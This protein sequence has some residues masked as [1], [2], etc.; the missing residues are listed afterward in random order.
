MPVTPNQWQRRPG[1]GEVPHVLCF[2]ARRPAEFCGCA[3]LISCTVSMRGP[4]ARRTLVERFD[5][6]LPESKTTAPPSSSEAP[7]ARWQS[8]P[9]PAPASAASAQEKAGRNVHAGQRVHVF[10]AEAIWGEED[11]G[12]S[13]SEHAHACNC[14]RDRSGRAFRVCAGGGG[15]RR[16][17]T[18]CISLCVSSIFSSPVS[19][20][21]IDCEVTY[22]FTAG[23]QTLRESSPFLV[24][25]CFHLNLMF[26]ADA[27][28]CV[29]GSR[30]P[31]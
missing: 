22:S 31:V 12:G 28:D 8:G 5:T 4:R 19:G 2:H 7:A 3:E 27:Y 26:I 20:A 11:S 25:F 16:T 15:R 24:I 9:G 21:S 30:T 29:Q 1:R 23:E 13:S 17:A 18:R 6:T 10:Y 14:E